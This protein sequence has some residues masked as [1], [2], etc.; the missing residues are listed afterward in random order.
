MANG[1]YLNNLDYSICFRKEFGKCTQTFV[2]END[3]SFILL[4]LN[5]NNSPTVGGGEAGVGIAECPTDYLRID[6]DR[7]CGARLNP[8]ATGRNPTTNVPVTGEG[9]F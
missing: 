1:G 4:N 3:E 2:A 7:Y 9:F 5:P 8:Q 6:G